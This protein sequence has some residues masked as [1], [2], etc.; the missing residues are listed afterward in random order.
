MFGTARPA[1]KLQAQPIFPN[2]SVN[3][4]RRKSITLDQ[5]FLEKFICLKHYRHPLLWC[6]ASSARPVG[7]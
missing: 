1:A 2:A 3:S 7:G 4:A 5:L 6:F